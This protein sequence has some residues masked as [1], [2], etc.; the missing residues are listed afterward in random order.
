MNTGTQS[1]GIKAPLIKEGDDI[2]KIVDFWDC[3]R[4]PKTLVAQVTDGK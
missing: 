3:R 4:N 2:V 1:I